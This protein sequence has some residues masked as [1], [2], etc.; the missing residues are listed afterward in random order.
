MCFGSAMSCIDIIVVFGFASGQSGATIDVYPR[1]MFSQHLPVNSKTFTSFP[2]VL[3]SDTSLQVLP[4]HHHAQVFTG[5]LMPTKQKLGVSSV[6]KINIPA[7]L[8]RS[9]WASQFR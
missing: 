7:K 1:S 9:L 4:T 5:Y 8:A 6:P 2:I 3:T